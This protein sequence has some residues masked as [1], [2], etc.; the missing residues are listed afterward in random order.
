MNDADLFRV[1]DNRGKVLRFSKW[2]TEELL[3][4]DF[5][6]SMVIHDEEL[7]KSKLDA[8]IVELRDVAKKCTAMNKAHNEVLASMNTNLMMIAQKL[9]ELQSQIN[10]SPDAADSP[11]VSET[12]KVAPPVSVLKTVSTYEW[13]RRIVV[14]NGVQDSEWHDN[15]DDD[16]DPHCPSITTRTIEWIPKYILLKVQF[17]DTLMDLAGWNGLPADATTEDVVLEESHEGFPI[18]ATLSKAHAL[19]ISPILVN[20]K[21]VVDHTA[22]DFLIAAGIVIALTVATFVLGLFE[23]PIAL[24]LAK[25]TSGLSSYVNTSSLADKLQKYMEGIPPAFGPVVTPAEIQGDN[26]ALEMLYVRYMNGDQEGIDE[27]HGSFAFGDPVTTAPSS[28]RMSN[29]FIVSQKMY[30]FR[31]EVNVLAY[32]VPFYISKLAGGITNKDGVAENAG[33]NYDYT[34]GVTNSMRDVANNVHYD[35][36][37][38]FVNDKPVIFRDGGG[39]H[40]RA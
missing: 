4:L 26:M 11:V 33:V 28:W 35:W 23:A 31:A 38:L 3:S 20:M 21:D 7:I 34:Y 40:E 36:N 18:T 13:Q 39:Y 9:S 19:D 14:L 5:S 1:F 27:D 32:Q 8:F 15:Y 37:V 2:I 6:A 25:V 16:L 24:Y 10:V 17:G 30:R 29:D 22:Q 12:I